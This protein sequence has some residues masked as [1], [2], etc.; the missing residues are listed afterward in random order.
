MELCLLPLEANPS[1][2]V[3]VHFLLS[4]PEAGTTEHSLSC[5]QLL[6]FDWFLEPETE[7]EESSLL[8]LFTILPRLPCGADCKLLAR[9]CFLSSLQ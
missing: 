8:Q 9:I 2:Q 6:H 1:P 4:S 3:R 7:T 5:A